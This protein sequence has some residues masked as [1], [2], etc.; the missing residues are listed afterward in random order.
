MEL[1]TALLIRVRE[2]RPLEHRV[3]RHFTRLGVSK[4]EQ[5]VE[6]LLLIWWNKLVV[7]EARRH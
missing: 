4:S 7:L 3:H 5:I 6:E 1:L 2:I